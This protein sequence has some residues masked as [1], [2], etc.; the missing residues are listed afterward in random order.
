MVLRCRPHDDDNPF[1]TVSLA[2]ST[3]EF[4]V[5]EDER[6]ILSENE[7]L[8]DA[9][10]HFHGILD[11][12]AT[13]EDVYELLAHDCVQSVTQGINATIIAYGQSGSGKSYSICGNA[14]PLS[15]DGDHDEEERGLVPRALEQLFEI[16]EEYAR[17]NEVALDEVARNAAG[18]GSASIPAVEIKLSFLEIANDTGRDLLKVRPLR[19]RTSRSRRGSMARSRTRSVSRS[20]SRSGSGAGIEC[21]SAIGVRDGASPGS[22]SGKTSHRKRLGSEQHTHILHKAAELTEDRRSA[23]LPDPTIAQLKTVLL[24]DFS[25]AEFREA[26]GA[27]IAQL[28]ASVID[29][30]DNNGDV[31]IRNLSVHTVP[32]LERALQLYARGNASR[33]AKTSGAHAI[34]TVTVETRRFDESDAVLKVS[35]RLA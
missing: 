3:L 11:E 16:A 5:P 9:E 33:A 1:V 19:S 6:E 31:E 34:F 14:S 15:T 28:K 30:V 2:D 20:R 29:A 35:V 12:D 25:E 7:R 23:G 27:I 17:D 21:A 4:S 22:P 10:F 26:R 13:Q 18:D 32:S 24:R 8:R